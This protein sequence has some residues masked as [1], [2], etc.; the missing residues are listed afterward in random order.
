MAQRLETIYPTI[1]QWV[2]KYGWIAI[3]QDEMSRSFIRAL[4]D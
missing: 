3:G 1:T 2:Q 4:D